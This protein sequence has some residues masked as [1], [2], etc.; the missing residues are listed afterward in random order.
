MLVA[1]IRVISG[2]G[3]LSVS[4]LSAV[5]VVRTEINVV[6]FKIVFHS[7]TDRLIEYSVD[8]SLD[9]ISYYTH[10][11]M[12]TAEIGAECLLLLNADCI[13]RQNMP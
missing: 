7:S 5:Q 6:K 9:T 2:S 3:K 12:E 8:N 1:D 10:V 13:D 11:N 4:R